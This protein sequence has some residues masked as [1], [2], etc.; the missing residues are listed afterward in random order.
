MQK[1][2]TVILALALAV[3]APAQAMEESL[4]F[5]KM[6]ADELEQRWADTGGQATVWDA[7]AEY[8]TDEL[9]LHLRSQ[10]DYDPQE[11]KMHR[12]DTR[13]FAQIPSG[14]FTTLKAGLRAETATGPDRWSLMVGWGG[15]MPQWV[16]LDANV[17][18]N[19][20]GKAAAEVQAEWP[21]AL[22]QKLTLVPEVKAT[23]AFADDPERD[24]AAGL[25]TET[26]LRLRYDLWGRTA[27]PYLGLVDE[28]QWGKAEDHHLWLVSGVRLAF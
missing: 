19:D 11:K 3:A 12:L 21:L 2:F 14:D 17:F 26:A 13:V 25:A 18:L 15:L 4:T 27:A 24:V 6:S 10:G 9:T 23:L 7:S 8:G 16:E 20:H 28:R 1:Q 5:W 22:S